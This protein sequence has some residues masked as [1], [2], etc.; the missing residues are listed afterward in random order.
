MIPSTASTPPSG[1]APSSPDEAELCCRAR[2]GDA[3]AFAR[4]AHSAG[5]RLYGAIY[6]V[7][8]RIEESRDLTQDAL[9]RAWRYRGSLQRDRPFGPWLSAIGVRLALDFLR[10]GRMHFGPA[11]DPE[12][13]PEPVD[14]EPGPDGRFL[15]QVERARVERALAALPEVARAV[16]VLRALEGLS[17]R[18][19]ARALGLSE[20]AVRVQFHRARARLAQALGGGGDEPQG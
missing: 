14:P 9:L 18:E 10:Q 11:C 19:T 13:L 12:S 16:V 3:D 20:G 2:Q 17:G 15:E 8:G 5:R 4:L 7:V 1:S 6:R